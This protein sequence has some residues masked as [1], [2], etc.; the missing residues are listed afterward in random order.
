MLAAAQICL[1]TKTERAVSCAKLP[2]QNAKRCI[3]CGKPAG[4]N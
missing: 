2:H 1:A 4:V 3:F